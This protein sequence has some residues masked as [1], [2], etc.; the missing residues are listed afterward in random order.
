MS[1]NEDA[2]EVGKVKKG[3]KR[4][5]TGKPRKITTTTNMR[6]KFGSFPSLSYGVADI[7]EGAGGNIYSPELSTD[8]LELPQS[9][10]EAWNYYRF[11]YRTEPFVG[12]AIDLHTELPLS[13]IRI[14]IPKAQNRELAVKAT[15]FCEK[16][17]RR[18]GLLRRLISI[19]HDYHLIGEV[20]IWTEDANPE[21][22]DDVRY[23]T[24]RELTTEGELLEIQTERSDADHLSVKWLKR[25]YK[26]WTSI[27][28]LPPEQI[29][30]ESF[31]F[32]DEKIFE[33]IPDSKTKDVINKAKQRD[34]D[35]VRIVTSMP[36]DVVAA[37]ASGN[38][39]PLNTD[40]EAGSFVYYMANKK[41]DYE[42]RGHSILERCLLPGTP[43]TV[44][45]DGTVLRVPVE[46]VDASADLLLTH[47]GRFR[48]AEKGSRP[49][50]EHVT[51][52]HV[53]GL[54][55]IALT[56]DHPVLVIGDEGSESWIHAADLKPGD[57][58]REAHPVPEGGHPDVINL[59]QWW[60]S[61]TFIA[62]RRV[63]PNEKGVEIE[64]REI[65]VVGVD[66]ED[67]GHAVTF[68]H[69][70][71]DAGRLATVETDRK[72]TAWL[73]GLT[74]PTTASYAAVAAVTDLRK[75][76][77]YNAVRRFERDVPSFK[78]HTEG[79]QSVWHPL[80][81]D[82]RVPGE[83]VFRSEESPIRE[84]P[85]T[86]DFA[87][88][89]GT[90][91][92][93][94]SV[95][96][97]EDRFLNT[98]CV[99]WSIDEKD[100]ETRN[101]IL[102]L[103]HTSFGEDSVEVGSLFPESEGSNTLNVRVEDA[104]LARWFR[105]EFGHSAQTK[106]IPKW[107]FDLSSGHVL[108]FLR[109][110]LDTDGHLRV[111]KASA[112][113][114]TLDNE[115]LVR[116][117]HLLCNR[118]GIKTQVKP[119]RRKARSWARRWKT[120]QGWEEK[121]YLYGE[122][123]FWRLTASRH[124]EVFKWARRGSIKGARVEWPERN[125][126]WGSSFEGGWLTRKVQRVES[127]LYTGLVH[128]FDVEQDESL[129]A[130]DIA[131]HNCIRTLVFRDKLRQANTSIASRHMTP[132][133][134]V[135]F[136]D[137]DAAD[138]DNVR[139]Q[140]DVALQDPDYS[141]VSNFQLNWEEMGSDQRLLDLS[142]EYDLTDRQLYAGLG[143][144]EGL[145]SGESAYSGDRINLEVINTRYMLLR[146]ILQDFVEDH[147]F[148]PMCA[149]MGFIE[150]D[151]DGE[152]EVITPKLSFTRLALRDNN[153]TFDAMM[154]LYQ[155]GSLDVDVILELL[156]IDPVATREKLERDLFTVNDATFN[157]A[158][159]GI[160][161]DVGRKIAENSD[162]ADRISKYL[163]LKYS[164]PEEGGGRF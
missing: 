119:V 125:H 80:P 91:F 73:K 81:E 15:K 68:E 123:T 72:L 121:E 49:V 105:D 160:Y 137:G 116:Q 99:E 148:K 127:V 13:K 95:W 106:R 138:V 51:V 50:S 60:E 37:V 29:R 124:A 41:S 132:I 103:C 30:M 40:P 45:R 129:V 88:L 19:V 161:S 97:A 47:K 26:G 92:G 128:S 104:L 55:P 79:R 65:R 20:F 9:L 31:N 89:L 82:S 113:E 14:T 93:D 39:I 114:I 87:Y 12:Q 90:W 54:D 17:A 46:D 64:A 62:D 53:E 144:T 2:R 35:A 102:D 52:L 112:V 150:E 152:E 85:V 16:W 10:H 100:D 1:K 74:G 33:L 120:V 3:G 27:R 25:N 136:E 134:V 94:G 117:I 21:M 11:F 24:V 28:V 145:L 115:T 5:T 131:V 71:D 76:D 86:E 109:G 146:E 36:E 154:N 111:G 66:V 140:V 32:T 162:A 43:I 153:D 44:L 23:E 70:Q 164:E 147:W 142:G 42:P 118:V 4:A 57:T 69:D 56:S 8:F 133:R 18:V 83:V 96:T 122:K 63:R 143:V 130:G 110:L 151:E 157:E 163:G 77:V 34:K 156:N 158:L 78:R 159:R 22:P 139:E 67:E 107:I 58:V 141:I 98:A 38:N 135:W 101:R 155:K 48:K 84:L 126:S 7:A 6:S 149:R 61:K 59:P 75:M 108:A